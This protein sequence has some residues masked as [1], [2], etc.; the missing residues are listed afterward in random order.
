[1]TKQA[2]RLRLLH[3]ID[4]AII[5]ETAPVAIAEAALWRL[6]DLLGVPRA[7]VNL[8]DWEAGEVEWLAAV[9]RHRMRVGPGVRYPLRFAGDLDALRRGEAQVIDVDTLPPGPETDA[10]R[11]SGVLVY[12]V[13]PMIV[14]D[15]LIG[16]V[17]F[18][19]EQAQFPGR[20]GEHRAARSRPS[21]RSPSSRRACSSRSSGT[22]WSSRAGSRSA[23]ASSRGPTASSRPSRTPSRTISRRRCA[24]WP[25]SPRRSRRTTRTGSTSRGGSSSRGSA[26]RPSGWPI[27]ST[28]SC[29]TRASSSARS[30]GGRWPSSRSWIRC[31]K[32]WPARSR[33]AA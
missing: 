3:E 4:R 22:P 14:G 7:I 19:G 26:P 8:F 1:M 23:P 17:S 30:S 32:T 25:A 15:Q 11:A 10:L 13:V 21:S 18:G 5:T 28:T 33:P 9:G 12:M 20:A 24:A 31:W 6:R 16:S 2:E 29:S 27:S